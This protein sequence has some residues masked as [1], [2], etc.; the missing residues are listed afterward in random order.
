MK[1]VN[2]DPDK[3]PQVMYLKSQKGISLGAVKS[4]MT[5]IKTTQK[6]LG[7]GGE[8]TAW[9]L[10]KGPDGIVNIE[11]AEFEGKLGL[12]SKKAVKL[13]LQVKWLG[14]RQTL[15]VAFDFDDM[16]TS[17]TNLSKELMKLK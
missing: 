10:K 1:W 11:K 6:G 7:I 14:K 2:S 15:K 3:D 16:A 9:I 12:L 8:A 4:A 13:K 17:I 5:L